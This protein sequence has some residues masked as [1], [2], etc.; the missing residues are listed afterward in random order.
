MLETVDHN[1]RVPPLELVD[2]DPRNALGVI[3]VAVTAVAELPTMPVFG[4]YIGKADALEIGGL[5]S[6]SSWSF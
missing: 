3:E 1:I 5:M 2:I 6:F 4:A